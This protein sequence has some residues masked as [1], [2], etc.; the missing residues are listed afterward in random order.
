MQPAP[1]RTLTHRP[2]RRAAKALL[3]GLL[4]CLGLLCA[5]PSAAQ[6]T[7]F[8]TFEGAYD[9]VAGAQTIRTNSNASDACAVSGTNTN[10]SVT[11]SGIPAGGT[12]FKA[13]LYWAGS[14]ATVDNT[15]TFNGTSR[16]ADRTFT[17]TFLYNGNTLRYFGGEKDVTA[18][19]TGNG[20]YTLRGLTVAT[21][22]VNG[23]SYCSLQTVYG[24]WS[25]LVIYNVP[26]ASVQPRRIS[27]YDG[28]FP[29]RQ[30]SQTI[31][32]ANFLAPA[33]PAGRITA[34]VFEGDPDQT[35]DATNA[36]ALSF[37]GTGLTDAQ[38]PS[39]NA[40]NSTVN[41]T[42]NVYGVD[43]DGYDVA[44]RIAAGARTATVNFSS[45]TDLVLPEYIVTSI[46]VSLANV[47]PD[48]GTMLRLPGT[49]SQVFAVENPSLSG[50][51]FD[52][53]ADV[54]D[55]SVVRIDSIKGTGI[56]SPAPRDSARV[57]LNANTTTNYTVYYTV[58]MGATSTRDIVLTARAV[59]RPTLARDTGYVTVQRVRPTLGLTKTVSP[60]NTLA[61]GTDLTYTLKTNNTGNFAATG[62]V[63]VDSVPSQTMFKL[64]TPTQSLPAGVTATVQYSADGTTWGYTPVSAA[65]SAPAG[66][67]ACVKKLR[68][69]FTGSLPADAVTSLSTLTFVARIR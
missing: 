17:N 36:E 28:I 13:Y 63:V 42:A 59:S 21:A 38:N 46:A 64:G 40:Y 47:T 51:N 19:V 24:G 53:L 54:A 15:V 43:L 60:N 16:T 67:D 6:L 26:G 2:A 61:P 62:V 55:T 65:C 66:F 14:G 32:L 25:L 27:L 33:A 35:G 8:Q 20:T 48:G 31:T 58:K 5:R 23:A 41:G 29:V 34:L 3:R 68:W 52:L 12:V 39:Q 56:A 1:H 10:T 49:S 18:F 9:Y 22:D 4:A 69:V 57:F 50:D 37:N 7:S 44:S 45:G 11:I 30:A